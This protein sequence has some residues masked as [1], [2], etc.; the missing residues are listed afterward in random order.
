MTGCIDPGH[1]MTR[2]Q[3]E[4]MLHAAA[5]AVRMQHWTTVQL[6]LAAEQNTERQ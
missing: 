5:D 3:Y 4:Q 1:V 2:E 6:D